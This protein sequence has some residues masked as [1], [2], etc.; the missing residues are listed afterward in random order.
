MSTAALKCPTTLDEF[1]EWE[2]RQYE[3]WEFIAGHLHM[4]AG[5][6][7]DHDRL[8]VNLIAV[9]R[10]RLRGHRCS[11]HASNLKVVTRPGNASMYPDLFIH[12]GPREGRRTTRE[13]PVV[14]FEVLSEGTSRYDLTRKKKAYQA[15]PSLRAIVYVVPDEPLL[16]IVHRT[17]D[18]RW[19]EEVEGFDGQLML[20]PIG[21]TVTMAEIYEDTDVARAAANAS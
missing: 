17:E 9:L 2:E 5:G 4:M 18:G 14:A 6:T 8:A 15:I 1:L 11:V 19:E 7:E 10:G 12:C 3:R 13:D 20:P 21:I 16:H